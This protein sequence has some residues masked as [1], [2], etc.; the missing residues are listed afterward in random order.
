MKALS[1]PF[2]FAALLLFICNNAAAADYGTF[3]SFYNA[4]G[5]GFWGWAG[6]IIGT[7]AVAAVTF[8]TFGGGAAAAP[9]WIAAVGTWIGS[10]VAGLSGIAA[11]N[12]GLALLGGGA[13]AAGGLGVAGGVTV[14]TTALSFTTEI[15]ISYGVDAA[16]EKYS[17]SEFIKNNK[18]MLTL[19]LPRN[20]KGGK[21]YKE[22]MAYLQKEYKTDQDFASETNQ[23]VIVQAIKLMN[24]KMPAE[25]DKDYVLKDNVL[26]AVLYLHTRN[27]NEAHKAACRAIDIGSEVDEKHNMP[28]FVKALAELAD[29]QRGCTDET[30]RALRIAYLQEEDNKL[31]PIMT[32]CCMDRMMY[33]YLHGK[34]KVSHLI[35][36][37]ELITHP[38]IDEEIAAQS[39]EIFVTRGLIQLKRTQQDIRI[40][41]KDK[42]MLRKKNVRTT[43]KDRLLRH[44]YLIRLL[45]DTA[46]PQ[47]KRLADELPENSKS[48]Y[49]EF[50]KLLAQYQDEIEEL[51]LLITK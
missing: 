5:I 30:L 12:F 10:S 18:T 51:D 44:Q 29:P 49:D 17:H 26:L 28:Y 46:L 41:A 1:K 40:V 15:A 32:G 43:L 23:K 21:A 7:I 50:S 16:L 35:A 8:I 19:P 24:E 14:L 27:Y 4:G 2:L 22:V 37:C 9:A 6:I 34:L 48:R 36:F 25:T 11:A 33:S 42:S 39:L 13:V 3:E 38:K 45:Q 31:Q 20:D 47:T